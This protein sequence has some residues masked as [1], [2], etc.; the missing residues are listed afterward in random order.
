MLL[1]SW[2]EHLENAIMRRRRQRRN[3]HCSLDSRNCLASLASLERL[4]LRG[5]LPVATLE[6]S[7]QPETQQRK[8][9]REH[10]TAAHKRG[11]V[12][13]YTYTNIELST[14]N[15]R[16]CCGGS[17]QKAMRITLADNFTA[18]WELWSRNGARHQFKSD[19]FTAKVVEIW[20]RKPQFHGSP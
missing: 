7:L 6:S 15:S 16:L 20:V 12:R 2:T 5:P 19:N 17:L 13:Y 3:W 11:L 18:G 1:L 10:G 8:T 14:H 4:P 9:R